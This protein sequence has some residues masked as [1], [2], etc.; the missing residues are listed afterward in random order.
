[1]RLQ[2]QLA[3][4]AFPSF[5]QDIAVSLIEKHLVSFLKSPVDID[6][7]IQNRY[8]YL[9]YGFEEAD[10]QALR[11]GVLKNQEQV[12]GRSVAEW[13]GALDVA[14][15]QAEN[16]ENVMSQFFTQDPAIASMSRLDQ[17]IL[18]R[19]FQ[20]YYD[21]FVFP[22]VTV[23]GLAETARKLSE[24]EKSG[25]KEINVKEFFAPDRTAPR[26]FADDM[27]PSASLNRQSSA[28]PSGNE[29]LPLLKALGKF[30][31][32]GGQQVTNSK[33]VVKG[34]NDPVR[35]TIFNWLRA[36]RDEL[37]VGAHDAVAR[38]QFLFHSLNGKGLS[39]DERDQVGLLLKS[40]DENTP[41]TIDAGRQEVVF[42]KQIADTGYQISDKKQSTNALASERQSREQIQNTKYQI[43]DTDKNISRAV[44][45]APH[46]MEQGTRSKEQGAGNREQGTFQT[47]DAPL[48][49]G[50]TAPTNRPSAFEQAKAIQEANRA[51]R[52]SIA[53]PVSQTVEL[54]AVNTVSQNDRS[55]VEPLIP[56]QSISAA[57]HES[58]PAPRAISFEPAKIDAFSFGESPAQSVPTPLP[59]QWKTSVPQGVPEDNVRE[60]SF[61]TKHVM[62]V[63]KEKIEENR[64]QEIPNVE[65]P[66]PRQTADDTNGGRTR[67][68]GEAGRSK[69]LPESLRESLRAGGT[70]AQSAPV[71]K[72]PT[73]Q[74]VNRYRI[75]PTGRRDTPSSDDTP[76][77]HV[78]DLRS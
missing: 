46:V 64:K 51:S 15:T 55:S 68:A 27:L 76:S 59:S 20:V 6:E 11:G 38:G 30:E 56:R 12:G 2:E 40:L 54:G 77:P 44:F 50:T 16:P 37:G 42:R 72:A 78:V 70:T 13:L 23:Y 1:M 28:I 4:T 65:R 63:E 39:S 48:K 31:K 18:R 24:L 3:Y 62:P 34:Q 5:P 17:A 67:L 71:K 57:V 61:S 60:V 7:M 8:L 66:L 69:S 49:S 75:T 45:E 10:R 73:A 58:A 33:I 35:P 52:V 22:V 47:A 43:Q 41:L 25:V 29:S 9:G 14:L 53:S 19:L 74:P 32:L 26:D 36:Y 21:F